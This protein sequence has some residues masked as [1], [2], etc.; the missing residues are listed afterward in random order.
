MRKKLLEFI[1]NNDL[2]F[3]GVGSNLNGA[4]VVISGYAL[5]L[6][7]GSTNI[8]SQAINLHYSGRK[9]NYNLELSNVFHYAQ[10]NHYSD[11]WDTQEARDLYVF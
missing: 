3:T 6:G 8:I 4:C 11:F 1:E 7:A 10:M 2:D 5:H 9:L